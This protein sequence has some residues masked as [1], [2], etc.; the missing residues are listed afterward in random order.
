VKVL[1]VFKVYYES[2][3]VWHMVGIVTAENGYEAIK[4]IKDNKLEE[5]C[6]V[7]GYSPQEVQEEMNFDFEEADLNP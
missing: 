5:I 2:N 3:D 1:E 4:K 7:T 6:S